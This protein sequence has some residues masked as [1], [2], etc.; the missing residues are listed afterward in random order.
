MTLSVSQSEYDADV[1]VSSSPFSSS[2]ETERTM[3]P[4]LQQRI[5]KRKSRGLGNTNNNKKND[6]SEKK[7][8]FDDKGVEFRTE[9]PP[10]I[11][12]SPQTVGSSAFNVSH[13][14]E[15]SIPL[16]SE[17]QVHKQQSGW[18]VAISILKRICG[19]VVEHEEEDGEEEKED[20]EMESDGQEIT[21]IIL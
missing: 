19:T 5:K 9:T 10:R 4:V 20:E 14:G 15:F 8:R 12:P 13:S 16:R 6:N 1:D 21:S 17:D 7:K 11:A 3:R 18:G 2:S